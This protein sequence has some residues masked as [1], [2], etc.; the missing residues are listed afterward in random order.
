M[1]EQPT[2]G[3]SATNILSKGVMSIHGTADIGIEADGGNILT[4]ATHDTFKS[5]AMNAVH[6]AD[7]PLGAVE[8]SITARVPT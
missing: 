4:K 6:S 7:I 8:A 3:C 5:P 2:N 1:L